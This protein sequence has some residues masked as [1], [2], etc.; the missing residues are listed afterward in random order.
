MGYVVI[1]V[2]VNGVWG[3]DENQI[4]LVILDLSSFAAWVTVILGT[5][6]ISHIVNLIKEKEIDTLVMLW[7]NSQVAY[8]LAVQHATTTVGNDK[9]AEGASDPIKTKETKMI[10]AFSSHIIHVKTGSA[11]TGAGLNMMTQALCAKEGPDNTE[12]LYRDVQRQQNVAIIMRNSTVYPQTLRKKVPVARA[13]TATWVPEPQMQPRM[14]EVIDRAQGIQ[15]PKLT[16]KQRQEKL[17]KKLDL[18]GLEAWPPELADSAWSLL[19]DYHDIFSLEPSKPG[20]THST[21]HVIKVTDDT[22]FKEQF[23]HIPPLLVEEVCTHLQEML[24]SGTICP[25][26]SVWCNTAVLV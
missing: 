20:C 12:H 22:P 17:F 24:D 2:H 8:L 4:A 14:I 6:T 3:Y 9:D 7:V 15:T 23:S 21:K 26:Q 13:A 16:M 5:P 10:D 18:S 25:S 19:V 11:C 1:W